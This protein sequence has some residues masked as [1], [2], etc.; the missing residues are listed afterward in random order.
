MVYCDI[1][2]LVLHSD[3]IFWATHQEI[4]SSVLTCGPGFIISVIIRG[5]ACSL[6]RVFVSIALLR[7]TFLHILGPYNGSFE[8]IVPQK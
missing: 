1:Y 2:V 8:S 4:S 3:R 7:L 5:F 6:F